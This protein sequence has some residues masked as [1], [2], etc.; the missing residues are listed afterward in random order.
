MS[1]TPFAFV[2]SA[3]ICR[4]PPDWH[5]ANNET[6]ETA[7]VSDF[8]FLTICFVLQMVFFMVCFPFLFRTAAF[9]TRVADS[10]Q[11]AKG[12][13]ALRISGP[14]DAGWSPSRTGFTVWS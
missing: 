12:D 9:L 13:C 7:R 10:S 5:D 6:I 1:A 4:S 3:V 8:Q 2:A 14:K 11:L